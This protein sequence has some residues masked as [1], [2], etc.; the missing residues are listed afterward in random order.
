MMDYL[1]EQKSAAKDIRANGMKC[2]LTRTVAGDSDF[3]TGTVGEPMHRSWELYGIKGDVG[4]LTR[5]GENTT[6]MGTQIRTGDI[7][8]TMEAGV[9]EP[10]PEDYIT[11]AGTKFEVLAVDG[12]DP[13]GIPILY[14]AHLRR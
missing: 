11:V 6:K 9:V 13:A 8:L 3:V 10:V 4:R 14:K 7:L 12:L 5:W 2:T 1:A